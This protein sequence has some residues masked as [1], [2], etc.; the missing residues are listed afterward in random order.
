MKPG[1]LVVM[2]LPSQPFYGK[3]GVVLKVNKP[4]LIIDEFTSTLARRI[5]YDILVENV[6]LKEQLYEYFREVDERRGY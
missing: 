2:D 3:P 4:D 1:A 5:S 6:V